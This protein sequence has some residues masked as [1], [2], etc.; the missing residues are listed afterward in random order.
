VSIND[1]PLDIIINSIAIAG[2]L[3]VLYLYRI[4]KKST[5]AT[6][7]PKKKRTINTA[8]FSGIQD[9]SEPSLKLRNPKDVPEPSEEFLSFELLDEVIN[10]K[11]RKIIENASSLKKPHPLLMSLTRDINDPK[12]L[13]DIIKN[14]P[15][16]VVKVIKVANSSLFA[17]R[18]SITTINHAIVYLGVLQAKNIAMQF[19]LEHSADFITQEQKRAYHRI[20]KASFLASSIGLLVAKD[21]KLDNSAELSTRCLLDYLGDISLLTAKPEIA[22]FYLDN[23]SFFE[24]VLNIQN[25]LGTNA[26]IMGKAFA[27]NAQLPEEIVES[28]GANTLPL[29]NKLEESELTHEQQSV[30]A[31]S[32]I[33]CRITDMII[34][35][36]AM[37]NVNIDEVSYA[38]TGCESFFHSEA[39]VAHYGLGRIN[40]TLRK[41][42]FRQDVASIVD[43]LALNS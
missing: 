20:W 41:A 28:I 19:A 39:L 37:D 1:I 17:L 24:R 21:L 29:V 35:E 30:V 43:K 36:R 5:I 6:K 40:S 18:K 4:S 15:E 25:V 27:K 2:L 3:L 10:D 26:S 14:D 31:F 9:D 42:K 32:Y 23:T 38:E 22:T 11:Q 7:D 13:M 8:T 12:E 33:I 34:F 16:L